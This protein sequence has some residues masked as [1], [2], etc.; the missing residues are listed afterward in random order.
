MEIME[1]VTHT[2]NVRRGFFESKAWKNQAKILYKLGEPKTFSELCGILK[3]ES[4]IR[5]PKSSVSYALRE[6]IRRGEVIG[7]INSGTLRNTRGRLVTVYKLTGHHPIFHGGAPRNAP[8][9]GSD[10]SIMRL[11]LDEKGNPIGRQF[12]KKIK[13][14]L[15][16]GYTYRK[17]S[18]VL[19]P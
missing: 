19:P 2:F 1:R 6:L 9:D 17:I 18:P 8:T 4:G 14:K 15:G 7:A 10:Y 12:F 11:Y 3:K 16:E 13:R 5:K